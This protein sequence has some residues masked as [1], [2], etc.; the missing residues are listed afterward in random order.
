LEDEL[1]A[2]LPDAALDALITKALEDPGQELVAEHIRSKSEGRLSLNELLDS[3]QQLNPYQ[4]E[5]RIFLG[6]ASRIRRNGWFKSVTS[7]QYVAKDIIGPYLT[8]SDIGFQQIINGIKD[9]IHAA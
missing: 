2:S 6:I 3:R 9:W 7:Y 4:P 5:Q 8:N 1:F